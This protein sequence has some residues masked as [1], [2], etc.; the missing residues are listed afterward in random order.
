[1]SILKFVF[2]RERERVSSLPL[3]SS[4]LQMAVVRAGLDG[5]RQLGDPS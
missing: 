2:K 3:A 5:N 4:F 1:M